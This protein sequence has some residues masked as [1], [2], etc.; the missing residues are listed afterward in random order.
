MLSVQGPPGEKT[1]CKDMGWNIRHRA[2]HHSSLRANSWRS[3]RFLSTSS[4]LAQTVLTDYCLL[5]IL[6]GW[7]L[8]F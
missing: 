3:A 6:K 7:R 5:V 2:Q 8:S 4:S 1:H